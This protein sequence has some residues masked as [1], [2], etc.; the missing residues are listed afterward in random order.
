MICP[1][2]AAVAGGCHLGIA[3]KE[4]IGCIIPF[5]TPPLNWSRRSR[6]VKGNQALRQEPLR[7][8]RCY[9]QSSETCRS[10]RDTATFFIS[11]RLI[12]ARGT[13]PSSDRGSVGAGLKDWRLSLRKTLRSRN[14]SLKVDFTCCI[15][16][17]LWPRLYHVNFH[18]IIA[19]L[20]RR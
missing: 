14:S 18:P 3:A 11:D 20:L 8:Y 7:Q 2:F 12:R 10:V 6:F 5:K 9:A 15:S 17:G 4:S 1:P 16:P 13:I 19:R